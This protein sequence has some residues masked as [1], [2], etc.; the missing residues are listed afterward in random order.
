[1][2][3]IHLHSTIRRGQTAAG[4]H[5]V[6]MAAFQPRLGVRWQKMDIPMRDADELS[7]VESTLAIRGCYCAVGVDN[8]ILAH[9]KLARP[10]ANQLLLELL[11]SVEGGPTKH[12]CHAASYRR[13]TRQA[14]ERVRSYHADAIGIDLQNLAD[15]G[16]DKGLVALAR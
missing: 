8:L 9:A 13:I 3:R 7:P 15:D 16:S 4:R 11:R 1:M 10:D 14:F 12:D 6:D 5:L 2:A